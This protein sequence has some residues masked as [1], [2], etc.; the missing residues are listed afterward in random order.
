MNALG[1]QG[2]QALREQTAIRLVTDTPAPVTEQAPDSTPLG[3]PAIAAVRLASDRAAERRE[4]E[5][6]ELVALRERVTE[7]G[8]EV[9]HL[10]RQLEEAREQGRREERAVKARTMGGRVLSIFVG[11][12]R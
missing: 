11:G 9:A 7:L 4:A 5:L 3:V 6:A 1:A 8:V 10:S 12:N 2:R